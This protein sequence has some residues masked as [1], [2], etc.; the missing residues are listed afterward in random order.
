MDLAL[1]LRAAERHARWRDE[2]GLGDAGGTGTF[3]VA[4][5]RRDRDVAGVGAI[6]AA[7]ATHGAACERVEP[8]DVPGLMPAAGHG[9]ARALHLAAERWLD[10]AVLVAAV[11]RTA[12]H[13]GNLTV[14]VERVERVRCVGGRA[15]GVST[16]GGRPVVAGDVILCTGASVPDVVT[17][18]GLDPALVPTVLAAK[19]VGLR[20]VPGGARPAAGLG[21]VL[22]TPNREF[23][24]GLHLVPR[25]GGGVYVGAT[26][27]ASRFP[28]LLGGATAGEVS[29]LLG[30]ALRELA[31]SLAGY[32]VDR[33]VWGVRPLTLDG[34]PV[35]GRTALEGLSVATGTYRNGV[36]LAPLL[37]DAV[38][39]ELDG[40][41][42]GAFSPT[43]PIA[44]ADPEAVV[45]TGL[46]ELATQLADGED[47]GWSGLLEPLLGA[48]GAAL[49]QHGAQLRA[50]MLDL[51]RSYPRAEM[52]PEA[53]IELL[54]AA[55]GER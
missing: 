27:R 11:R 12:E 32:D 22:R 5:A 1:R 23:A 6:E 15:T 37:A 53:V 9:A 55:S 16:A 14:I 42:P 40:E 47:V 41:A 46:A 13:S 49:G 19:G 26:N 8:A 24:C 39:A 45:R 28:E 44:A 31:T 48:A 36:L 7:A 52:V 50:G 17:A 43:R 35:A 3:V 54:Q 51:L 38:A 34:R 30:Q 33:V 10:P 29:L 20:L 2:L 4:S 18:S 21:H 25:A